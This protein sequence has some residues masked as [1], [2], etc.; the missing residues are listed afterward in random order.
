MDAKQIG[1]FRGIPIQLHWGAVAVAAVLGVLVANGVLPQLA[2][3]LS[4]GAYLLGGLVA[5]AALLGSIFAHEASHAVVAQHYGVTVSSITLWFLGGVAQ[6]EEEAPSPR[7]EARIA[8]A[9]PASS[10]LI[11]AVMFVIG[12]ILA[13]TDVAPL[14]AA[15]VL[16]IGGLNAVLAVFNLLPGAPLDGG[17]LLH[18]WLWRR[19]GDRS[20]ATAG[21]SRSGRVLG[22]LIAAVGVAEFVVG[23]PGG[24]WTAFVGWFLYAAAGQEATTGR[25]S[26]VLSGRRLADVMAPI[27]PSIANWTFLRDVLSRPMPSDR[28]VAVDFG[29]AVTLI[30]SRTEVVRAT[31]R[32][33]QRKAVP[34]RLRDLPFLEPVQVDER[35]PASAILRH[36]GRPIL[37]T[38]D[39]RPVGIITSVDVDRIV[40]IHHL[41]AESEHAAA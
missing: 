5:G 9:G 35:E 30:T 28:I 16:W 34:E 40:A 24:L 3:G 19:H 21:A 41:T 27:P 39:S 12:G 4:D 13:I 36:P 25:L 2:P 10:F 8:G 23:N 15:T 38:R 29:G 32:A 31:A 7:A 14:L 33:A 1:S 20:R 22:V 37:V 11:A 26:A 6:L 18:A 17:R